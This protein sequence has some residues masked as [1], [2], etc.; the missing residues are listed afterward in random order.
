MSCFSKKV[1]ALSSQP[2]LVSQARTGM[3]AW[4]IL[5][6][7]VL[8][9]FRKLSFSFGGLLSTL[10]YICA[11][12][13]RSSRSFERICLIFTPRWVSRR[14]GMQAQVKA[15]RLPD[16]VYAGITARVMTSSLP[17]PSNYHIE[18]PEPKTE[19]DAYSAATGRCSQEYV[20]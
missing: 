5:T 1:C 7:R 12:V 11:L 3:L 18:L 2:R 19:H 10:K 16:R 8:D 17:S 14:W 20:Y 13:I 9:P 6:T 15:P 4:I